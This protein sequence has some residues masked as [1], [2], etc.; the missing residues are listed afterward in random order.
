MTS[1]SR[2]S[3]TSSTAPPT[4]TSSSGIMKASILKGI[5][6]LDETL[7]DNKNFTDAGIKIYFLHG[8]LKSKEKTIKKIDEDSFIPQP[9]HVK[10]DLK[11]FLEV[12]Q[13]E[14]FK[15]L[16]AKMDDELKAFLQS[17]IKN[18]LKEAA[19]LK[20]DTLKDELMERTTNFSNL[21]MKQQLIASDGCRVHSKSNQIWLVAYY[22]DYI[23]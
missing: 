21:I 3:N 12:S 16:K 19:T 13:S 17:K 9:C 10:M 8:T 14:L 15:T 1:A 6:A 4:P 18:I 2:P 7:H 23:G 5:Q 20:I 11:A 22:L